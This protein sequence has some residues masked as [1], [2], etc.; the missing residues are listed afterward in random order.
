MQRTNIHLDQDQL[1]LL[2]HLAAEENKPVT[3]FVFRKAV[4]QFL[5]H[6]LENDMTRQNDMNDPHRAGAQPSGMSARVLDAFQICGL[7]LS[8]VWAPVGRACG[9]SATAQDRNTT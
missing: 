9:N 5:R 4:D 8:W 6:R 7:P 3:D 1:R 2:K